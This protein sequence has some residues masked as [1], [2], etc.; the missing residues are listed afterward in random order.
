ML[1]YKGIYCRFSWFKIEVSHNRNVFEVSTV[2]VIKLDKL[3]KKFSY[4]EEEICR[5]KLQAI[6]LS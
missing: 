1:L 5:H 2:F 6:F 4:S 3:L